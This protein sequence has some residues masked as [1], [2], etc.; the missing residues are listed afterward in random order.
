MGTCPD[1]VVDTAWYRLA[2]SESALTWRQREVFAD[3]FAV[4][5][6]DGYKA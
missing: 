5:R 3:V 2:K 1:P 6:K 4:P